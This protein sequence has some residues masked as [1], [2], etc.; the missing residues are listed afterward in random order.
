MAGG[1]GGKAVL[2]AAGILFLAQGTGLSQQKHETATLPQAA[3]E[4][5]FPLLEEGGAA[6]GFVLPDVTGAK[7][8]YRKE[9]GGKPLLLAFFSVF[10]RPCRSALS[11]LQDIREKYGGSALET[12]A[13]SLD[14]EVL[15]STVAG[16]MEQEGYSFRVL[17]DEVDGRGMFR[18]AD[19]YRVAEIPTLYLVDG[20]G[21]IAFAGTGSVPRDLLDPAV[22][23]V[24]RR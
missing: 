8:A 19:A 14:G 3:V 18:V 2:F 13:I 5:R 20:D 1:F 12:A 7:Y 11:T 17:L 22:Q 23:S 6:P 4:E 15:R 21:R 24:L 10:C 9:A 16:F